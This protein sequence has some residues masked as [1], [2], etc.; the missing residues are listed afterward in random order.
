[1]KI[2]VL[3]W[4][5]LIWNPRRNSGELYL[6][7]NKWS[8][9]GP[10][11]PIEFARLSGDKRLTLVLFPTAEKVQV[12]W[13]L[14]ATD[15]LEEA[16]ENLR[17][18][19]GIPAHRKNKIGFVNVPSGEQRSGVIPDIADNIRRWTDRKNVDAVIWTDLSSNFESETGKK[20]T[21]KNVISYLRCLKVDSERPRAEEYIRK[22]PAQIRTR[23][24][25]TIEKELGWT[26]V[27]A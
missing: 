10:W 15:D 5:S 2:T 17:K 20:T 18:V 19:E 6:A 7:N 8:P 23:F 21:E 14:M 13:A 4:G 26:P 9:D 11:L 16:I 12:L 22:A 3:G 27:K 1:M 24:R 25:S